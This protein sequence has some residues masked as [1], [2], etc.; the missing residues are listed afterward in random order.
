MVYNEYYR[1]ETLQLEVDL[2]NE[3]ILNRNWMKDYFTS[4]LPWQQ[5]GTSPAIPIVG[6]SSA[7]WDTNAPV[8]GSAVWV[9]VVNGTPLPINYRD[10]APF[11]IYGNDKSLDALNNNTF[12][13]RKY[14]S[15]I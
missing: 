3:V 1:D 10:A 15:L 9:G 5:R 4:S 11:R 6:T 8:T 14:Q 12:Y 7:V 13:L 2:D